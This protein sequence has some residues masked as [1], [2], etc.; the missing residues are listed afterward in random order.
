MFKNRIFR[1]WNENNMT[2][3]EL[4][5]MMIEIGL[6]TPGEGQICLMCNGLLPDDILERIKQKEEDF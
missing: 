2:V 5:N 4:L 3:I 6:L 1:L